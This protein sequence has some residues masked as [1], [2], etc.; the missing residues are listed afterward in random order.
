M[1]Q[2]IEA[3]KFEINVLPGKPTNLPYTSL[4]TLFKGRDEFLAELRQHL[5]AEGPVVING[6]RTING[7]RRSC[8][9]SLLRRPAQQRPV[10]A[11]SIRTDR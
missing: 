10:R 11:W 7:T 9:G 2:A 1:K 4:G 5:T 3:I 6:M 8:P